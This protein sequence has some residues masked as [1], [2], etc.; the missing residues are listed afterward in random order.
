[1]GDM[2]RLALRNV[3]QSLAARADLVNRSK[4]NIYLL[5]SAQDRRIMDVIFLVCNLCTTRCGVQ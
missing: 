4:C 2:E 3:A 5:S 1:M